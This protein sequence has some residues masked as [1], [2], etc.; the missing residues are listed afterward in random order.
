MMRP[1]RGHALALAAIALLAVGAPSAHAAKKPGKTSPGKLRTATASA[2]SAAS[3][4]L[5]AVATCPTGTKVVGGGF[6]MQAPTDT[7]DFLNPIESRREG[8]RAWLVSA[9]RIDTGGGG[10]AMT[11]TAEAYCRSRPGKLSERVAAVTIL[12]GASTAAPVAT[13]PLGRAPVGGGFSITPPSVVNSFHSSLYDNLMAGGV[14]WVIRSVNLAT[15]P[16]TTG[17]TSR[18]YCQGKGKK[19][20]RTVSGA[21]AC[22]RRRSP[23]ARPRPRPAPASG[24]PSPGASS[25]RPSSALRRGSPM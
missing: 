20:P 17:F 22:R 12:G 9:Y 8:G 16:A 10:P 14:G 1:G 18:A 25:S 11:L 19:A 4:V 24:T 13:C 23:P 21:G 2:S 15:A 6:L 5:S 7:N 3:G